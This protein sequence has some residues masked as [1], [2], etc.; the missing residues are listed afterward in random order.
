[1]TRRAIIKNWTHADRQLFGRQPVRLNH[2][3]AE[4]GL[5]SEETLA[6]VIEEVPASHYNLTTMGY[7]HDNPEWKEGHI[8]GHKGRDVIDA[9]RRGRMW[10]NLNAL[11]DIDR[12]YRDVLDQ[13]MGDFEGA[14][15]DLNTF[16][17]SLGVLVSSPKVRVFYHAD[18]PGQS[19]WQ[20]SGRKRLYVYPNTE[21]FLRPE[22][23]EKIVLGV[24]EE[25]IPYQPW[26][27]DHAKVFELGPGEMVHWPVNGPHQVFN[28][29]CLNISVTTSHWTNAIRNAYAVNYA[30]GV[31]RQNFGYAPRSTQPVGASLYAKAALAMVWKKLNLQKGK[32]YIREIQFKI[33]PA[34]PTGISTAGA[35]PSK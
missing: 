13:M 34:D 7:D 29:D 2:D 28:E 21:P 8:N 32:Q 22:D 12:R 26:F 16:R 10:L 17:R 14:V 11:Q 20:V 4:S 35:M 33:D 31:L 30:N 9:I 18:V 5:F 3:L 24:T 6:E 15:D 27:D 1:M 23:M 25:E 19:L